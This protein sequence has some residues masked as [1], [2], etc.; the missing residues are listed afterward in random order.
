MEVLILDEKFKSFELI[1]IFDSLLWTERYNTC[2]DFEIYTPVSEQS[3]ILIDFI[4]KKR[5][6][7]LDMY[8]WK[9]DTDCTMVLE[10]CEITTSD[11]EGSHVIISGRSLESLL[12]RRIIWSQTILNGDLQSQIKKMLD[13][14][15]IN[16][17]GGGL[18]RKFP[19]FIFE[20]TDDPQITSMTIQAQYTGDNL[21]DVICGICK[22]YQIGFR[23]RLTDENQMAFKLYAGVDRSYEQSKNPYVVFSSKFENIA[24]TNYLESV[25]TLKNLVLVAGEDSGVRRRMVAVGATTLSGLSRREMY[26]DA[27][28]I[29][30]ETTEGEIIPDEEYMALLRQRGYEHLSENSYTKTFE[31]NIEAK[32]T[33]LYGKDFFKGDI[34]QIVTDYGVESRVRVSEFIQSQNNSGYNAYPTFESME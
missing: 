26:V 23:V 33:F 32:Q 16:P 9:K 11:D 18:D 13:E 17:V 1:D 7:G 20:E 24:D 4:L 10:T 2:G 15:V 3:M 22:D 27:R 5:K 12:D 8:V 6:S 25:K 30:S 19:N 28:D 34:V 14:N 29:Q 21:Y 31:G